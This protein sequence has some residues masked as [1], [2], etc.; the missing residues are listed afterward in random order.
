MLPETLE[1]PPRRVWKSHRCLPT[2]AGAVPGG[3]HPRTK[4]EGPGVRR[5]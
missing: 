1:M 5:E 3:P 2:R 4:W